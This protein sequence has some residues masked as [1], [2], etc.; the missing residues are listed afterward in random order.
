[1]KAHEPDFR[2]ERDPAGIV[3][4]PADGWINPEA[5][6]AYYLKGITRRRDK[7][8]IVARSGTGKLRVTTAS[9]DQRDV[10]CV[11]DAAGAGVNDILLA[12]PQTRIVVTTG[13]VVS[14]S[15]DSLLVS[16]VIRTESLGIRPDG[17]GRV[18]IHCHDIDELLERDRITIDQAANIL[19]LRARNAFANVSEITAR[20]TTLGP[21][22]APRDGLPSVG[23]SASLAGYYELSAHSGLALAPLLGRLVATEVLGG[24]TNSILDPF[25]PGRTV[26]NE[27]DGSGASSYV[28]HS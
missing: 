15:V 7:V 5:L 21:R 28:G 9:G 12:S 19:L 2:L 27:L 18:V 6:R 25:R 8:T 3:W 17:P 16:S 14:A 23:E 11:V 1:M 24:A 20:C 4:F 26:T 22:P 13:F 10:D